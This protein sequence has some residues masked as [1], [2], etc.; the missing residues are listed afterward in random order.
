MGV[1]WAYSEAPGASAD[2]PSRLPGGIDALRANADDKL[3]LIMLVHPQCPCSRASIAE[4]SRVMGKVGDRV[5]ARVFFLRPEGEAEGWEVSDLWKSAEAIPG[6]VVTSDP[7]G[8][9]AAAFGAKTSG[10]VVLYDAEG[11]LLFEGGI[12]S[13]RGHE[14]DNDGESRIVSLAR[15]KAHASGEGA[16]HRSPVFGCGLFEEPR[17]ER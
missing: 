10:Q 4:L 12:T 2:A 7:N 14:G 1:L 15:E 5:H 3:S 6:V 13:A 16:V 9:K 17:A 8:E 11:E